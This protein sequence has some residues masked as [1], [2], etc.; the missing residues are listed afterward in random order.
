VRYLDDWDNLILRIWA[1][2]IFYIVVAEKEFKRYI[3]GRTLEDWTIVLEGETSHLVDDS[4]IVLCKV[5]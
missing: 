1:L 2:G 3:E 4:T 5:F